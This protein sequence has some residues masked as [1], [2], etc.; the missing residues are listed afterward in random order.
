MDQSYFNVPA[1][2]Y[3]AIWNKPLIIVHTSFFKTWTLFWIAFTGVSTAILCLTDWWQ[4]FLVLTLTWF[5]IRNP[6]VGF[7]VTIAGAAATYFLLKR[8]R[9]QRRKQLQRLME[10]QRYR[11]AIIRLGEEKEAGVKRKK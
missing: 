4:Q 9:K 5:Y 1:H 10:E 2:K 8:R 3:W 11:N 7:P 6:V